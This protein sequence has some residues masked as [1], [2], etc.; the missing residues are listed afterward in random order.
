MRIAMRS[1]EPCEDMPRAGVINIS[2][3]VERKRWAAAF[4]VSEAVLLHAVRIVGASVMEL[5][6]LFC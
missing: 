2:D 4:G 1:H 3:A 6:K 5:R